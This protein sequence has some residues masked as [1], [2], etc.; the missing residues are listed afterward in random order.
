[1][2]IK[3]NAG[4]ST[5]SIHA[6]NVKD[7]QYGALSMPIYQTSTFVFENCEQGGNRFAG[8][9]SG[10]IY[11][12]LGNPN[13]SVLETKLATLE[14]AEAAAVTSSGM[15]AISSVFWTL[16]S[17][18]CHVIADTTLYGCTYAFLA[19][20]LSKFGVEVSF[21]DTTD[22][23]QLKA[24]LKE[25]TVAVYL[26]TPANPNLKIADLQAIAK[27]VHQYS[28]EINVISDNT[29]ATPYIQTPITLGVDIVV[30]S[31]TKYLNGHG[32]VIA[33]VILGKK[34]FINEVKMLGIKDMTGSV[35]GPNEAF[36][37][38]RGLK[39]LELR[40]KKHCE[41]AECIVDYLNTHEMVEKVYYPGL[42][43]HKNHEIAK[44]Q[45]KLF[46]GMISFEVKGGKEAG[47]MLLDNLKMC[48]LAVSLGD[49]E[50]LV[51]HPASMTHSTYSLEELNKAGIPEG[52]VRISVGLEEAQD[53]IDDLEIGFSVLD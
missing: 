36:L 19:H 34:S 21:I 16:C 46:G 41:N 35:L 48:K 47:A 2:M 31:A 37:I 22:M 9:E 8:E 18:G 4:F 43:S 11:S 1:M 42:E 14:G 7:D 38:L 5:K 32:D 45:M 3:A 52:L 17:S 50:T 28:E 15:G 24:A 23:N 49:A 53:I 25:N 12:R 13:S 10:Y 6:G 27:T 29:F 33:G 51:E 26:E 30:H 44:K 20:G 40:M 39:T